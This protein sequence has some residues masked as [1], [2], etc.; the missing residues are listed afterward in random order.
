MAAT[1]G[2]DFLRR[3]KA[4]EGREIGTPFTA[5]DPVNQPMIRHWC[6]AMGDDNPVY[7]DEE[8]ARRSVHGGIVAPPTMLQAW[9][10]RGLRP[11]P[12]SGPS[13]QDELWRLFEEAGYT[14]IVAV[15]CE[16]E[17][18]RYL[19]PGDRLTQSISI[20]SVSDEKKTA[21]GDGFFVTQLYTF[22]DQG[23]ETVGTMRFRLFKYRPR[24]REKGSDEKGAP[25]KGSARLATASAA[26]RPRPRPAATPD[27]A[28]FWQGLREGRLP[29]QRCR[30]CGRLRHPP[31]PM[32]PSCRSLEWE[33]VPSSGRGVV[34]SFVVMHHPPVPGFE[35]PFAVGLIELE[36]G[37]R[38]VANII[39]IENERISIGMPVE[40]ELLRIDDELTLPQFRPRAA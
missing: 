33:A 20:E 1:P 11:P 17:Y 39:G 21:L 32:C 5:R 2:E 24:P 4:F 23:G 7:T 36:E 3:I 28:F 10:M 6:D 22:R 40:L 37:V 9:T 27:T 15:N 19:R 14:S 30:T 25:G 8:A 38:I 26:S 31:E 12:A 13:A 16:Q 29:I 34:Y 35:P 18:A